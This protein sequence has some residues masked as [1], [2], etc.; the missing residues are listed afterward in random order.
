[1][2]PC[3]CVVPKEGR[4][5]TDWGL[6]EAQLRQVKGLMRLLEQADRNLAVGS[7]IFKL[8]GK[9]MKGIYYAKVN[10]T[11]ALRPRCCIGPGADDRVT[12]LERVQKIGGEEIPARRNSKALARKEGVANGSLGSSP[13]TIHKQVT[14]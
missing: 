13:I 3:E 8:P 4:V 10:G 1:M 12:F 9:F 7:I 6:E 14:K 2:I 5:I 11:V